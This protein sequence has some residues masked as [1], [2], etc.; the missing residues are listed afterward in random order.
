MILFNL[1]ISKYTYNIMTIF[2]SKR[3]DQFVYERKYFDHQYVGLN[4]K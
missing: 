4:L 1:I 3:Y 2:Y